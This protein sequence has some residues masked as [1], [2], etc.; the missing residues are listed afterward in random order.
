VMAPPSLPL[1]PGAINLKEFRLR[2]IGLP[3][4]D[5]FIF[6][7][8]TTLELSAIPVGGLPGSQL[9]NFLEASPALLWTIHIQDLQRMCCSE[10]FPWEELLLSPT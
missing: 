3:C 8:L 7:N 9:L 2:S 5:R 6:P 1:F 4:L 10:T